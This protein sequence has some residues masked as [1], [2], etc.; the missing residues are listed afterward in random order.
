MEPITEN[1]NRTALAVIAAVALAGAASAQDHQ[2]EEVDLTD[3][4]GMRYC[5][6]LLIFDDKVEIY[7]TSASHGCPEDKWAAMDV[8]AMA[9]N[10]GAKKA[11]LNGPHFW[12][13]DKQRL[14][15]GDTKTFGGI[16]ARYAATLPLAALGSGKGA[17]PYAPYIS[18][19][20]Q[21]MTFDA[22]K[23]IYQLTGPDGHTYVMNAYGEEVRSGDPANL[24]DQLSPADGWRFEVVTPDSDLV[25]EGT[26]DKPVNMVGDDMHQYYTRY[27]T[28]AQ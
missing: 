14:G 3:I 25:I 10:H 21:T 2:I 8:A 28:P 19:K 12:A 24:A 20:L 17:D 5:E 27:G 6:M 22:G 18:A 4:R 26:M 7:N 23:P 16:E 9:S 13:M 11:Q 1:R 15:L